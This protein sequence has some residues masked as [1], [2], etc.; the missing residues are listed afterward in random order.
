VTGSRASVQTLD[1]GLR[2]LALVAGAPA[3]LTVRETADGLGV[4]RTVA[5]RLL[6]TL[7]AHR[8]VV[9]NGDGRYRL[10]SGLAELAAAVSP[11]WRRAALPELERLAD[12]VAATSVLSVASGETCIALLSVEPKTTLLHVAYRPGLRHPLTVGASGK[13]IL[14]GRPRVEGEAAEVARARRRGYA[15]SRGELQA[16]AVGIAAPVLVDAWADASVAVVSLTEL[17]G[18]VPTRVRAAA[19]RIAKALSE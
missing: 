14:G 13:A 4:H 8:L 1:R 18:S 17:D 15:T 3:G 2:V 19:Q 6:T 11:D 5:Y 7:G 12:D 9:K 16:G 10:G